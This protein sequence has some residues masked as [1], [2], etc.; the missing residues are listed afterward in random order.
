MMDPSSNKNA[1]DI[2]LSMK[3]NAIWK[4]ET[5]PDCP[6]QCWITGIATVIAVLPQPA[7]S[8]LAREDHLD[9]DPGADKL[10]IATSKRYTCAYPGCHY[11][12]RYPKD[13]EVHQAKH[14]GEK[15][16]RCEWCPKRYTYASGLYSHKRG[17]KGKPR[18]TL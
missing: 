2:V 8:T 10:P 11:R 13:L 1:L 6:A 7:S 16:F 17:C 5:L 12:C 9:F 15:R 4:L 18:P 14:T 3:P